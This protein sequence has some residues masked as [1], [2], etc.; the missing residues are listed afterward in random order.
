MDLASRVRISGL[1]CVRAP[2]AR[3]I[4]SYVLPPAHERLT[5]RCEAKSRER[6]NVGI[7]THISVPH[8]KYVISA[9]GTLFLALQYY[10]DLL[11]RTRP[12]P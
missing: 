11:V 7:G 1:F 5:F 10:L 3:S 8:R 12:A 9:L 6:R 4:S 2:G